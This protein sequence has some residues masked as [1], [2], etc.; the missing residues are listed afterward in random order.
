MDYCFI[1]LEVH[2]LSALQLIQRN[3]DNKHPYTSVIARVQSLLRR[4]WIVELSHVY[5]EANGAADAFACL[6][7]SLPLGVT[8]YFYAPGSVLGILRDDGYGVAFPT[9]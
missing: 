3:L 5:R 2:S 8:H 4:G 6:S 1:Q 7:H 9:G